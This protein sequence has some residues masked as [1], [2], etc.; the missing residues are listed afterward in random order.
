M[1]IHAIFTQAGATAR[2][3]F[4]ALDDRKFLPRARQLVRKYG[5]WISEESIYIDMILMLRS[6][7]FIGNPA[8][9][10]SMN[11]ARVR[12]AAHGSPASNLDPSRFGCDD[13]P[14]QGTSSDA[15]PSQGTSSHEPT[16]SQP[17]S[18]QGMVK[19]AL[20]PR[21]G[22]GQGHGQAPVRLTT[23]RAPRFAVG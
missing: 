18:S 6:Q 10:V 7:F 3:F 19:A 15:P 21:Q 23:Q 11:V 12:W 20:R 14:S 17:T 9:T 13:P 5:G 1:H 8:S 4:V 16:R 2:P 22:H